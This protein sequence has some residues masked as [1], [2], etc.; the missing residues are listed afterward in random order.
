[1]IGAV[2]FVTGC[3]NRGGG[4]GGRRNSTINSISTG[5]LESLCLRKAAKISV[6]HDLVRHDVVEEELQSTTR[7]DAEAWY[8]SWR[9]SRR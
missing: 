7:D 6:R 2:G 8:V 3:G 1:M 5:I 9:M 4:R